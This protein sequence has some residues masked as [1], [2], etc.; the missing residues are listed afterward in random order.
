MAV[1]GPVLVVAEAT[2]GTL[3]TISAEL[4]GAGR[5]LADDLGVD[6]VA[7]LLSSDV[8]AAGQELAALGPARV[9]V[10]DDAALAD[11][12]A[13]VCV[14]VLDGVVAD[15]TPGAVLF[16]HTPAMREVAVRLAF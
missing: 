12:P 10:A 15:R 14:A 9:L 1:T 4:V 5:R 11:L 16:G 8:G 2:G 3:A 7:I 13:D 6:V